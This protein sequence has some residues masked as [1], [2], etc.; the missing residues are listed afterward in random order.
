MR[1][2]DFFERTAAFFTGF[3]LTTLAMSS[4]PFLF[5][6]IGRYRHVF[7]NT[8]VFFLGKDY[9]VS[10]LTS[11]ASFDENTSVRTPMLAVL[12]TGRGNTLVEC[13]RI[14]RLKQKTQSKGSNMQR[15][16]PLTV[17][18]GSIDIVADSTCLSKQDLIR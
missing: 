8:K 7:W 13:S 18:Q 3:F 12:N 10:P 14:G 16:I 1:L 2:E 15:G 11:Q 17:N 6:L 5:S 9:F 4:P